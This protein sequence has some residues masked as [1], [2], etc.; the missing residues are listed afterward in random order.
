PS[1]NSSELFTTNVI[2]R[3]GFER[4]GG[5]GRRDEMRNRNNF[6]RLTGGATP[7]PGNVFFDRDAY[8]VDEN[9]VQMF[10]RLIRTNGLLGPAAA[11]VTATTLPAGPGA[12]TT[13]D[14]AFSSATPVWIDTGPPPPAAF[15]NMTWEVA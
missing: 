1:T 8:T 12:A 6:A 13:N 4:V 11:T 9:G 5:G 15:F 7:G 10:L 2:I 14:F 3:G